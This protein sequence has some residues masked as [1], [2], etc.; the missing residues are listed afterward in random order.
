M[1]QLLAKV[2][3][4]DTGDWQSVLMFVFLKEKKGKVSQI[5]KEKC[6]SPSV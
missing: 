4:V 2:D 6:S 1:C 3:E 5:Y